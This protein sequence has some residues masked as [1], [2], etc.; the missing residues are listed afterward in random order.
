MAMIPKETRHMREA[1]ERAEGRP[2]PS[3]LPKWALKIR[4]RPAV[5]RSLTVLVSLSRIICV[6]DLRSSRLKARHDPIRLRVLAG[7]GSFRQLGKA[8]GGEDF[9]EA[10]RN[11]SASEAM[12]A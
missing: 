11:E 4:A 7:A 10:R 3:S 5:A 2:P 12:C 9:A 8:R 1:T 6:N